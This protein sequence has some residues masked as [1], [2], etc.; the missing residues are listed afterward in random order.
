M[1]LHAIAQCWVKLIDFL[2]LCHFCKVSF[3]WNCSVKILVCMPS[4]I[5][6]SANNLNNT[7]LY[8]GINCFYWLVYNKLRYIVAYICMDS[9]A[10]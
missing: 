4:F 3:V 5:E 6:L 8:D 7:C 1:E 10:T 9:Q 2:F